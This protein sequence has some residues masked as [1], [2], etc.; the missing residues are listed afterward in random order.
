MLN[1]PFLGSIGAIRPEFLKTVRNGTLQSFLVRL[2]SNSFWEDSKRV[3]DHGMSYLLLNPLFASFNGIKY[4]L[5][6]SFI[7]RDCVN[8]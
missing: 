6:L 5:L 8:T 1:E 2:I 4:T 3:F 7:S